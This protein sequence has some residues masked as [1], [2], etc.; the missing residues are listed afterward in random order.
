VIAP[1]RLSIGDPVA[2]ARAD[3]VSAVLRPYLEAL[4]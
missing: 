2:A 1:M 4:A 3:R